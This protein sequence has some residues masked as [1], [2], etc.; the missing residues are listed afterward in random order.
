M[1]TILLGLCFFTIGIAVFSFGV[2]SLMT[3]SQAKSW[4][5]TEGTNISSK[6]A[7]Y[8]ELDG[9]LNSSYFTHVNYRY[10]VAGSAGGQ[11][12]SNYDRRNCSNCDHMPGR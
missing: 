12:E 9:L 1:K 5:T 8:F 10:A 2:D 4:P 7:Y 11:D 3:A 6:C